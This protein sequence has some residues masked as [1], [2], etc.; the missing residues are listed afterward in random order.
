MGE[1]GPGGGGKVR[2]TRGSRSR[3]QPTG[4]AGRHP[5]PWPPSP[6]CRHAPPAHPRRACW[7]R[8]PCTPSFPADRPH[9]RRGDRRVRGALSD[10]WK[11]ERAQPSGVV[12]AGLA[13]LGAG[14]SSWSGPACGRW[15]STARPRRRPFAVRQRPAPPLVAPRGVALR[16]Q[17][18]PRASSWSSPSTRPSLTSTR[19]SHARPWPAGAPASP[20]T[21]SASATRGSS[22][23]W[24][25]SRVREARPLAHHRHPR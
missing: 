1:L 25:S 7:R 3:G 5:S 10:P 13:A 18:P 16:D 4:A 2:V 24:T 22:R 21:I 12:R 9:R 14:A 20:S 8:V 15:P 11:H 19:A 23:W 17:L 6:I